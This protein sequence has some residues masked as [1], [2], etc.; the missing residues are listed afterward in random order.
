V[1]PILKAVIGYFVDLAVEKLNWLTGYNFKSVEP[2]E[3]EIDK[4]AETIEAPVPVVSRALSAA[5]TVDGRINDLY[6]RYGIASPAPE[7][8]QQ[9]T[10]HVETPAPK[11]I[12]SD[13][14]DKILSFILQYEGGYVND[15]DDAGGETN[16]GITKAT[17]A[18]AYAQGLVKHNSVK[19]ITKEDA[20]VIYA[21][22][23]YKN[24]GYDKLPFPVSIAVT[25]TTVN[26]G[27]GGAAKIVQKACRAQGKD[28][29]VD[30]KWG[31]KT[32][33]AVE[34]LS[35]EIPS[36]FARFILI[37]RKNYYDGIISSKPS[38]AK[39]RNGWY[40]R[41]RALASAAGVISP[42]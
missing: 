28:I 4:L 30:G 33:T 9:E 16:R 15:P 3:A 5:S 26:S 18:S 21:A 25:D 29:V 35:A 13:Q 41:L 10:T 27:R 23:Y 19:D 40:N 17:L 1:E 14:W 6:E 38:Q 11:P 37:E 31:P 22:R 2:S 39:F 24:Y 12:V 7:V 42:V 20:S 34:A 8:S 32:Q 36:Q